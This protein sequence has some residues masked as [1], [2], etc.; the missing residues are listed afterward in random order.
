M[1]KQPFERVTPESVGLASPAIERFLDTLEA[2]G[3]E[4]LNPS[5]GESCL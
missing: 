2:S 1:H 3:A 5:R 4:M